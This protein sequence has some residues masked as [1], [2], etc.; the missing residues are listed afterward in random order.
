MADVSITIRKN[1]PYLV[2][3]MVELT[4]A[5]GNAYPAKDTMALCRCGAS[6]KKPF[7]D[8]THSKTG[9]QAAEQAVPGSAEG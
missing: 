4:D 2:K 5:D 9:F 6:T 8:G 1:G 3:G 7:C